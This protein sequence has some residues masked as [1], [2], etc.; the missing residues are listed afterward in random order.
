MRARLLASTLLLVAV[1]ILLTGLT[2]CS[3]QVTKPPSPPTAVAAA[4]T[5]GGDEKPARTQPASDTTTVRATDGMAMV[6][7]PAGEFVMG[8]DESPFPAER[9]AHTVTLD[10]YFMDRTE[11]SNAQYRECLEAVV[12]SE[13]TAW[14][15][16]VWSNDEQP[17][18]VTWSQAQ[19]YCQWVGGVLPSEAQWE[20]AARGTDGHQWPWG[21]EF[22]AGRANLGGD[23]DGFG[24][25]SPVGAFASGASP[26]GLLDMAGNAA[27]WVADWYASDYYA[28]SA[29]ENPPGPSSGE[30]RV[31]RSSIA[32]AGGGPEKCRC[33]ARYA[34]DPE[35]SK[36][37]YGF[38]CTVSRP[39]TAGS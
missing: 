5:P 2:A 31:Y 37:T 1:L 33:V 9:P 34:G 28:H 26:Y 4:Q 15:D 24:F 29:A 22:E 18:L 6:L 8:S 35:H 39:P 27:E 32:N 12:C 20:K 11:V 25:T 7:I 13:P 14:Q 38:R 19:T 21:D 16:A 23:M 17:A 3:G 30:Q 10:T 36:W